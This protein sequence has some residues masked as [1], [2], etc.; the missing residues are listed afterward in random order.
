MDHGVDCG[1]P[2]ICPRLEKTRMVRCQMFR[3]SAL[4]L[5]QTHH[6]H[7]SHIQ[8]KNKNTTKSDR[9]RCASCPLSI[10]SCLLVVAAPLLLLLL[11]WFLFSAYRRS[12]STLKTNTEAK[13]PEHRSRGPLPHPTQKR[14]ASGLVSSSIHTPTNNIPSIKNHPIT[15]LR[16][17]AFNCSI[18][19]NCYRTNQHPNPNPRPVSYSFYAVHTYSIG[20]VIQIIQMKQRHSFQRI[21]LKQALFV[22]CAPPRKS[23]VT[24]CSRK[25]SCTDPT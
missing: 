14:F 22:L 21:K 24:S 2:Q 11:W 20:T 9:W 25:R 1:L 5:E 12:P 18:I 16:W 13:G 7:I 10:P 8:S 6:R 15:V 3:C 19:Q 4:N 17:T 23:K